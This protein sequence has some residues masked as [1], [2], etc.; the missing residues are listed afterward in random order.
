MIK[1][2]ESPEFMIRDAQQRSS[3]YSRNIEDLKGRN[4][5]EAV[6]AVAKEMEALFAYEMIKAM[7]ETTSSDSDK[8]LGGGTYMSLFDME[9]SRLFAERGLGLQEILLKGLNRGK[10]TKDGGTDDR[11]SGS[12]E[13]GKP[14]STKDR[15][16]E[17]PESK[18]TNNNISVQSSHLHNPQTSGLPLPVDGRISSD[19]GMRKHP[20]FGDHRFHHG[21]DIAAPAGTDIYPLKAGVVVFSGERPGYGNMVVIDHEDGYLTRYAH[22]EVNL[23]REGERVAAET[24]IAKVGSTGNA[25]GPHL[26]FEVRHRGESINPE[27]LLAKR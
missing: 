20:V 4:D 18:D 8:G 9:L 7:R 11:K 14:G 13:I 24:V 1:R 27:V 21:I 19:F 23:V 3:G 6:K 15:K 10:D 16:A 5:P 26:H 25:T 2:I 12:L 22:N 17:I